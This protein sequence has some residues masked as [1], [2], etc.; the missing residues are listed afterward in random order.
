MASL[1]RKPKVRLIDK[2]ALPIRPVE[3]VRKPDAWFRSE[4][5]L[6]WVRTLPSAASGERGAVHPIEACHVRVSTDGAAGV[7]PSDFFALPLTVFEHRQ[8]HS[9]SEWAY[10]RDFG[11][12]DPARLALSY[13]ERSPCERTRKAAAAVLSGKPWMEAF[14]G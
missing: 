14:N 4:T 13:A 6:A 1:A 3:P 2:D 10:W 7:K 12:F 8:Q 11:V 9:V 5:H